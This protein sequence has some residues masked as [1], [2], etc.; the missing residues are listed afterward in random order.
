MVTANKSPNDNLRVWYN[1]AESANF[2]ANEGD[3]KSQSLDF[4]NNATEAN[5]EIPIVND[6]DSEDSGTITVTL[7]ND[8]SPRQRYDGS[9]SS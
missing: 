8:L 2:I 1:L 4:T 6:T 7:I 5:L 3:D 9:S